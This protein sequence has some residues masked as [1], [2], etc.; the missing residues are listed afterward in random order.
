MKKIRYEPFK[1]RVLFHTT[2]SEYFKENVHLFDALDFLGELTQHLPPK[3]VRLIRRYGLYSS[4]T[5]GRWAKMPYVIERAP[6]GWRKTH[7]YSFLTGRKPMSV[8]S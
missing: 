4:R 6:D 8:S 7:P 2:Y 3:G 5:K 1:E